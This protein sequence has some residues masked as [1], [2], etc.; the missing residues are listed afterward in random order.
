MS[1]EDGARDSAVLL[2]ARAK[3]SSHS[4]SSLRVSV[5]V[6]QSSTSTGRTTPR[7][8][9]RP[10][11]DDGFDFDRSLRYSLVM[12]AAAEGSQGKAWAT[13]L[14]KTSYLQGALVLA[15]SLA[16]HRSKYPLVVFATQELPQVARDTLDARGIRVRDIDFL[17]PPKENRGELDEHDRR[18]ADTW[19]KLRVF[20]MTEFEVRTVISYETQAASRC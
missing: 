14:T 20:E 9:L 17:E 19:T 18:F 12:V 7:P 2:F 3:H 16:R 11:S 13:L 8:N 1:P 10:I 5:R 6:Y 4:Q 15:D